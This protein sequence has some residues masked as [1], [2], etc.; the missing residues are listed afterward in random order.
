LTDQLVDS[1]NL[2]E[3]GP[4]GINPYIFPT[5]S[6]ALY[7]TFFF[8][9]VI[10]LSIGYT[11]ALTTGKLTSVFQAIELLSFVFL[12]FSLSR[13]IKVNFEYSYSRMIA[14]VFL[15]WQV[16]IL[17][18]GDYSDMEYMEVKQFFFDLNYGGLI[19]FIPLVLFF[20]F[21]IFIV[22]RLFTSITILSIIFAFCVI[23]NYGVLF[24]GDLRNLISLGTAETYFKYLALPIGLLA[25]NFNLFTGKTKVLI[26]VVLAMII[27]IGIFRARRGMIFMAA[28]ISFFSGLNYF[29]TSKQKFSIFFYS[30]YVLFGL[31]VIFLSSKGSDIENISFFRNI[32]ERGLEDT[33]GY[34]E[35]CFYNDMSVSD[36]FVGK[37]FNGGYK[38][39]GIDDSI[40]KDGIRKVIETDY[41]QLIMNGGIVNLILLFSIMIPAVILGLFYSNNNLIKT[42]ALWILLWL[43][44][45][46]PANV[47][48]LNLFHIS[49]WLSAGICF[50][51]PLRILT[52]PFIKKYFLSDFTFNSDL[53]NN[54]NA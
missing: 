16:L 44:F 47:Y 48:S 11:L 37:G 42:F 4:I 8:L 18:R 17:V 27:L 35:T 26:L 54:N 2:D 19:Y 32:S 46:Y 49:V 40:F 20:N 21:N 3:V 28:A 50:T 43:I 7:V 23:L 12:I 41:L 13:L 22:K 30:I 29:I 51:R 24:N 38:C 53:K 14:F 5:R 45:L 36:W 52:N 34:V 31:G 1:Q 10:G 33:R 6:Y 25:L 15:I 9:S 39:P